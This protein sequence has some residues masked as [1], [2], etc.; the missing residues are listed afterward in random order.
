VAP[1]KKNSISVE[2]RSYRDDRGAFEGRR[3]FGSGTN[4]RIKEI[5][6]ALDRPADQRVAEMF[7][8]RLRALMRVRARA[9]DRRT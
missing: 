7:T 2:I 5:E 4:K 3:R 1:R 9:H 8:E 6:R